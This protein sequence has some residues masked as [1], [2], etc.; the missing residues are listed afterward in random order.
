MNR[1]H[2][3]ARWRVLPV[4]LVAK[5]FGVLIKVEGMPFGSSR[6]RLANP[7]RTEDLVGS[8]VG[9]HLAVCASGS[10]LP[11]HDREALV[12][13]LT[14][15][16]TSSTIA[17]ALG[18]RAAARAAAHAFQI[19][20]G[21]FAEAPEPFAS[22]NVNA[23]PAATQPSGS[24]KHD[25]ASES[26]SHMATTVCEGVG[27]KNLCKCVR[28]DSTVP[29]SATEIRAPR[30]APSHLKHPMGDDEVIR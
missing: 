10:P 2:T 14:H 25:G 19:G 26:I 24:A 8:Q 28:V 21:A 3:H 9:G 1:T 29:V 7:P 22:D 5:L 18:P 6:T 17:S 13:I 30:V 23:S 15:V 16:I 27:L 4:H 11:D 20:L 12:M